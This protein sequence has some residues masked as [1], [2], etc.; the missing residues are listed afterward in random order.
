MEIWKD[1]LET[2]CR[3][4]IS[5]TG[6]VRSKEMVL[7]C[8]LGRTHS[9]KGRVLVPRKNNRGYFRVSLDGKNVFIHRLVAK[10]F[11]ANPNDYPVVN[12][13]DEDKTNNN[14]DNLEWCTYE[15]N[16]HYG[17]CLKRVADSS[18]SHAVIQIMPDG[19][20]RHW[21]SLRE[22]NRVLG[23]DRGAIKQC[24]DSKKQTAYNCR[25]KYVDRIAL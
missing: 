13:K 10:Y 21:K 24:C 4:Q 25:W 22:V 18:N 15:Y 17:S 2:N 11:V 3:Y 5:N 8:G 20:E 9:R 1:I 6:K 14:A 7:D 19:E 23:Y 12:H 16:T